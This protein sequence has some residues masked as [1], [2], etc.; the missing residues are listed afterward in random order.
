MSREYTVILNYYNKSPKL[1]EKQVKAILNQTL[2]PTQ[3]WA[4]FMGGDE[5]FNLLKKYIEVTKGHDN[6]FFVISDY[7]FKYIGR[8]QLALT[9]QT[10]YIVMLDDDRIPDIAYCAKMVDILAK[11]DCIVQ[12]YGWVL[13]KPEECGGDFLLPFM[14]EHNPYLEADEDALIE[15]DYLCG[16]MSFR[17]SSLIHLFKEDIWTVTTGEDI[18]FCFRAK[19]NGIPVYIHRPSNKAGPRQVLYHEHEGVNY[20]INTPHI[21]ELRTEI[22][23]REMGEE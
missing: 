15:A 1:L 17:K 7:N 14:K 5:K 3:I 2:P 16:G 10:E 22:I 9:A 8:Y 23:K 12:Q 21:L 20:T 4:C 13:K 6:A 11:Q 19:K 18:M